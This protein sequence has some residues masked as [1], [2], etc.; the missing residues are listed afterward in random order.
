MKTAKLSNTFL[1]HAWLCK[2]SHYNDGVYYVIHSNSSNYLYEYIAF[3]IP[4]QNMKYI[5]YNG[6]KVTDGKVN[7]NYVKGSMK[8]SHVIDNKFLFTKMFHGSGFLTGFTVLSLK[9]KNVFKM[10]D[11]FKKKKLFLDEMWYLNSLFNHRDV[12]ITK[13]I[14]DEL[15]YLFFNGNTYLF[16]GGIKD[17]LNIIFEN[18]EKHETMYTVDMNSSCDEIRILQLSDKPTDTVIKI[19]NANNYYSWYLHGDKK[20]SDKSVFYVK[21]N[22]I[23]L[24]ELFKPVNLFSKS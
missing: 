24:S 10:I 9:D 7:I 23:K 22:V 6:V 21:E 8:V 11:A 18:I 13:F 2:Y 12:F 19:T 5:F 15:E 17:F 4:M 14:Y 3:E 1:I 16:N 20:I